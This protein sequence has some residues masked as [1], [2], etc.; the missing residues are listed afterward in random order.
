MQRTKYLITAL[1]IA[2]TL[3]L[4]GV[5][6]V[7]SNVAKPDY[8]LSD[9]VTADQG[10]TTVSGS[11]TI[12]LSPTPPAVV[13][14][15]QPRTSTATVKPKSTTKIQANDII[16]T[17]VVPTDTQTIDPPA[18]TGT[19]QPVP[20]TPCAPAGWHCGTVLKGSVC[21]S[22]EHGYYAMSTSGTTVRCMPK[23]GTISNVWY[24]Q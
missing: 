3:L 8:S 13:A 15:P 20:E 1:A 7:Y 6:Y 2:D 23:S 4:S 21:P 5:G 14:I 11:P 10:L 12:T 19:P 17:E 24:W 18:P 16:P 22:T 9:A